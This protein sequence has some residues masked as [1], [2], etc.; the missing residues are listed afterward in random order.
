MK[1]RDEEVDMNKLEN[2]EIN[3][4]G[5]PTY[6]EPVY[7]EYQERPSYKEAQNYSSNQGT[8]SPFE[9]YMSNKGF[10]SNNST[11]A[12]KNINLNI[13]DLQH[14]GNGQKSHG[15]YSSTIT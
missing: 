3:D 15:R 7:N 8:S 14:S 4:V 12:K 11:T 5:A 6:S 10:P 9:G 1:Q 13:A 2:L